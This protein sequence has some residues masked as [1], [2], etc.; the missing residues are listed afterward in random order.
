MFGDLVWMLLFRQIDLGHSKTSTVRAGILSVGSNVFFFVAAW[1]IRGGRL[2][3]PPASRGA[4]DAQR[5]AQRRP[6]GHRRAGRPRR[7]D[8]IRP[9]PEVQAAVGQYMQEASVA[10]VLLT[11]E[12]VHPSSEGTRV[13]VVDGDVRVI[14]GLALI[15]I[16]VPPR[17]RRHAGRSTSAAHG[18]NRR[19][20]GQLLI[21]RGLDLLD[22]NGRLHGAAGPHAL[23]AAIAACHARARTAAHT[24]WPRIAALY[25]GQAQVNPSPVVKLNRAVA[26]G[27]AF[28]PQ[29]GLDLVRTLFDLAVMRGYHLL[30]AVAG[31]L[32][33]RAGDHAAAGRYFLR[34]AALTPNSQE[35]NAMLERAAQC[36]SGRCGSG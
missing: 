19:R 3:L 15:E 18:S 14:D 11:G 24:D 10:G 22:R 20:W 35:R 31:D 27:R 30:P 16:Q 9:S 33:C 32:S 12:G 29:A 21:R 6:R 25:D 28:G 17:R 26:V 5:R 23:Q 2:G 13:E 34:A 4:G 36:G 1:V 8:G 7:E